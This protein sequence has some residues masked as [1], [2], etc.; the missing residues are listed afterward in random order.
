MVN[1][2]VDFFDPEDQEDMAAWDHLNK[3]GQWPNGYLPEDTYFPAN[4]QVAIMIKMS[5]CWAEY[6]RNLRGEEQ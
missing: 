2:I 3:R 4:W 1:N 5:D 6:M